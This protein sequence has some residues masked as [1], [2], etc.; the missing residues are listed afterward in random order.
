MDVDFYYAAF[1]R[2]SAGRAA[3]SELR[4]F[5]LHYHDGR[6]AVK[7]DNRPLAVRAADGDN[8]RLT[9]AGG[10]YIKAGKVGAGT[11][12]LLLWGAG[13]FGS[14]GR[15]DHRAAA[16]AVEAGYAFAVKSNPWLRAIDYLPRSLAQS[17]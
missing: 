12:D 11:A 9:T 10:N 14:W 3:Q 1:T 6:G 2:P 5:V 16:L 4:V 8:V 17:E 13:Q 15:L 7:T